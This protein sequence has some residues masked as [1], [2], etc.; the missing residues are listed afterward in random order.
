MQLMLVE[1]GA[2]AL[3]KG[4]DERPLTVEQY[5]G[6]GLRATSRDRSRKI[7]S[8]STALNLERYIFP[9]IGFETS[10]RRSGDQSVKP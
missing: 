3:R 9:V 4:V 6:A 1:H 2:A 8:G 7:R 5:A 10:W